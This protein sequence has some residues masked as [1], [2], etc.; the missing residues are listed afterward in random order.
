MPLV[1]VAD[2]D[3]KIHDVEVTSEGRGDAVVRAHPVPGGGGARSV[4]NHVGS[5]AL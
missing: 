4:Y 2:V 1:L 5:V 3:E